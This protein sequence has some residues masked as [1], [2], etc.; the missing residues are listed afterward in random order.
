MKILEGLY[1][2]EDHEWLMVEEEIGTIGITDYAQHALGDIV[3]VELPEEGD[4]FEMKEAFGAIESV[5][6]ASDSYM[7][8]GGTVVEINEDLEDE[9]E[10]LNTDCYE[11]WMVKIRITDLTE[12]NELMNANEYEEFISEEE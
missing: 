6:A 10:L 12:L 3:F 4:E 1:Y 7:P 2:T 8:V 11:N 9:P 5:K